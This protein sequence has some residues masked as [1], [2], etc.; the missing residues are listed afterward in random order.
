MMIAKSC[1]KIRGSSSITFLNVLL[2]YHVHEKFSTDYVKKAEKKK[3]DWKVSTG[4]N[5]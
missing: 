3:W 2:I 5:N 4:V 1:I